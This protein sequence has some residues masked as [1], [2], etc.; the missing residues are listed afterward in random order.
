MADDVAA[1]AADGHRHRRTYLVDRAFQLKYALLMAAAGVVVSLAFG[2]WL[3]QAHLQAMNLAVLDPELR[4]VME[5]GE[6]ELLLAFAGIAVLMAVALGL[7]G[8]VITHRV[9]GPIFVMGHYMSVVA[10]GRFPRMRTLRR[11]DELRRFFETFLG[12]VDALKR[13]EAHHAVVLAD[14]AVRIRA[15]A[16]RSP[17]LAEVADALDAAAGERRIALQLDD[18]EPTPLLTPAPARERAS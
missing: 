6:R 17:D 9:A 14:A 10:Q 7:L 13:R 3:H 11:G 8:V 15:A 1:H 5:R 18:P 4:A 16:P 12:A 2:L